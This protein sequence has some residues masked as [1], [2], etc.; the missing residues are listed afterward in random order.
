MDK[1]L[2]RPIHAIIIHELGNGYQIRRSPILDTRVAETYTD[3]LENDGGPRSYFTDSLNPPVYID[4]V[5][6]E[7]TLDEYLAGLGPSDA[8]STSLSEEGEEWELQEVCGKRRADDGV[9]ELLV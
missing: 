2:A 3:I 7:G 4:G 8:G 5:R 6:F 1:S 9:Q